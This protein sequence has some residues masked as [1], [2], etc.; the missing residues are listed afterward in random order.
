LW[1]PYRRVPVR[2]LKLEGITASG[3]PR[4]SRDGASL[5]FTGHGNLAGNDASLVQEWDYR[6][7]VPK[8]VQLLP[9]R[10]SVRENPFDLSMASDVLAFGTQNGAV[11]VMPLRSC[12]FVRLPVGFEGRIMGTVA[13][14]PDGK[15]LATSGWGSGNIIE[16]WGIPPGEPAPTVAPLAETPTAEPV[17]CPEIPMK[18][19]HPTP[20][21]DW[22]GGGK[23]RD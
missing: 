8:D 9:G 3:K 18:V 6:T 21:N 19:E 20:R 17:L 12:R 23:P 4:F 16:L 2:M 14:R 13:F 22:R 10:V 5:F 15:I 7:G 11:Y 1:D